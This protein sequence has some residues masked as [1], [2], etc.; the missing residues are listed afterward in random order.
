M[1]RHKKGGFAHTGHAS[2]TEILGS[3]SLDIGRL[4]HLAP[5]L[6]FDFDLCREFLRG[7][8]DRLAAERRQP[9]LHVRQYDNLDDL[10]ID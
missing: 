1:T 7:A 8:R 2:H 3:S 9:I 10:A 5:S 4:D 6:K